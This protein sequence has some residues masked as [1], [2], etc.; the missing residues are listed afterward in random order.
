VSL[1]SSSLIFLMVILAAS[2]AVE[3]DSHGQRTEGAPEA[4]SDRIV[5][6]PERSFFLSLQIKHSSLRLRPIIDGLKLPVDR[7][8]F[9]CCESIQEE[10]NLSD[11]SASRVMELGKDL[12]E[13]ENRHRWEYSVVPNSVS[14][15]AKKKVVQFAS[16]LEGFERGSFLGD[17][18]FRRL[19]TLRLQFACL[20]TASV[21]GGFSPL[22]KVS[23]NLSLSS[24]QRA[25]IRKIIKENLG[26]LLTIRN[27]M[28]D[29]ESILNERQR[30]EFSAIFESIQD[31]KVSKALS[32]AQCFD[33]MEVEEYIDIELLYTENED[34]VADTFL[35][36]P[37]VLTRNG[38]LAVE[39]EYLEGGAVTCVPKP[40]RRILEALISGE[41]GWADLVEE[42]STALAGL[43]TIRTNKSGRGQI[44]YYGYSASFDVGQYPQADWSQMEYADWS[45]RF[46]EAISKS[47]QRLGRKIKEILLPFQ[48]E[49][50]QTALA[51]ARNRELGL[52]HITER[53]LPQLELTDNQKNKIKQARQKRKELLCSKFR[54]IARE[55]MKVLSEKQEDWLRE[56]LGSPGVIYPCFWLFFVSN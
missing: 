24:S 48:L 12:K 8:R 5:L 46:R 38:R 26:D 13:F 52:Y 21:L 56:N 19:D 17:D 20:G 4:E 54:N 3:Q 45:T 6:S 16:K 50:I 41:T 1:K 36:G 35:L 55:C 28:E 39:Q 7:L 14:K 43:K 2:R 42:Q 9:L 29:I 22:E 37:L 23:K 27:C 15:I 30:T 25:E 11:E 32:L 40:W 33:L 18:E 49:S 34:L 47:D 10:L 53:F 31:G 44:V 51:I